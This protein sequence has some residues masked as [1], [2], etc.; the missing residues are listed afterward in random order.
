VVYD[1][2]LRGARELKSI[3]ST[4]KASTSQM[5]NDEYTVETRWRIKGKGWRAH[6][7]D[8]CMLGKAGDERGG[9]IS[10]VTVQEGEDHVNGSWQLALILCVETILAARQTRWQAWLIEGE[11]QRMAPWRGGARWFSRLQTRRDSKRG[12][13]ETAAEELGRRL[14][15]AR[16]LVGIKREERKGSRSLRGPWHG[17]VRMRITPPA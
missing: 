6:R 1:E 17:H 12:K 9:R 15:F 10:P 13:G 16:D 8:T 2:D 4:Y 3:E 14:G 11:V 5:G 7:G